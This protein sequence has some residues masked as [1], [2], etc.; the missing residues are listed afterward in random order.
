MDA[1]DEK[2]GAE[3]PKEGF[4]TKETRKRN[5]RTKGKKKKN[6][7]EEHSYKVYVCTVVSCTPDG[8]WY[9]TRI[10]SCCASVLTRSKREEATAKRTRPFAS[11]SVL[12]SFFNPLSFPPSLFSPFSPFS[13]QQETCSLYTCYIYRVSLCFLFLARLTYCL[14]LFVS[15]REREVLVWI[16]LLL[17][18]LAKVSLT[19]LLFLRPA[20]HLYRVVHQS[21][22]RAC[23]TDGQR[24][25]AQQTRT[26]QHDERAR[27]QSN[28]PRSSPGNAPNQK[29]G[30]K[31]AETDIRKEIVREE[32]KQADSD[33]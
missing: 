2:K 7:N 29:T 11:S 27:R 28:P 14:S 9:M 15:W 22:P 6:E 32:R 19:S 8:S 23:V 16:L 33:R 1:R 12:P 13:Y 24:V 20:H 5:D 3:R 4:A 21:L 25:V 18:F 17:R 26:E 30:K 10:I 31:T